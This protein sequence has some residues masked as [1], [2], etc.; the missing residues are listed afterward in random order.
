M[1]VIQSG[2]KREH[3]KVYETYTL[4]VS[5]PCSKEHQED[6]LSAS[7]TLEQNDKPILSMDPA[8]TFKSSMSKMLRTLCI[9]SQTLNPLQGTLHAFACLEQFRSINLHL[10]YYDE[11]TPANYE[12]PG[13][14]SS[15]FDLDALFS[16]QTSKMLYGM[17][18]S[19]H[20]R[21]HFVQTHYSDSLCQW[22]HWQQRMNPMIPTWPSRVLVVSNLL[23]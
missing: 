20:H 3:V 4:R 23:K 14:M 12:P 16:E 22:K 11:V 9:N 1:M 6:S 7:L 21:Y 13:F 8:A 19:T 18:I 17:A 2:P 10:T 15:V 5:Y